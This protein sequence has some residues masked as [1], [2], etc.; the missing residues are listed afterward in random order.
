MFCL[1]EHNPDA[2]DLHELCQACEN[3][4]CPNYPNDVDV[5]IDTTDTDI[6]NDRYEEIP[7]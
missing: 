5:D 7:W 2:P 4:G 1:V 3:S 6:P